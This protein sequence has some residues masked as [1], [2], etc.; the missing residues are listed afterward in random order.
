MIFFSSLLNFTSIVFPLSSWKLVDC[1]HTTN[2]VETLDNPQAIHEEFQNNSGIRRKSILHKDL[3]FSWNSVKIGKD[4]TQTRG[5]GLFVQIRPD[6]SCKL[7]PGASKHS[8]QF[9]I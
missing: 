7:E 2:T 1:L 4:I 3:K 9:W 6:L 5:V 8:E